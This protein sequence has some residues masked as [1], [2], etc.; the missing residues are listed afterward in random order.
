ME[1]NNELLTW[2]DDN[3]YSNI[4]AIAADRELSVERLI[5]HTLVDV[6]GDE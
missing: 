5:Y 6:F 2:V 3:V 1:E 4:L